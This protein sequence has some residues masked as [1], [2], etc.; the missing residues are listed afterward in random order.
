MV[1]A[2]VGQH[3]APVAAQLPVF[4]LEFLPGLPLAAQLAHVFGVALV[5]AAPGL[6][7]LL[8]AEPR[9]GLPAE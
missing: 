9:A 5:G 3:G 8:H 6:R 7:H 1:P 4:A 2:L